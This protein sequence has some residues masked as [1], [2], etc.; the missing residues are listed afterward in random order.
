MSTSSSMPFSLAAGICG[1]ISDWIK[2]RI[3]SGSSSTCILPD[4]MR[5][6]SRMSLIMCSSDWAELIT[7]ERYSR[8]SAVSGVSRQSCVM[9]RMPFI[10]V[11]ISWLILARKALFASFASRASFAA[12]M[13]SSSAALR[14]VI[15]CKVPITRSACCCMLRVTICPES[16]IQRQP[17]VGCWTRSSHSKTGICSFCEAIIACCRVVRSSSWTRLSIKRSG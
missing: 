12:S 5:E 9:P 17:C 11:R 4:S 7:S 1:R 10:G 2:G 14:W 13:A 8:C 15:S 16:S 6:K 3:S